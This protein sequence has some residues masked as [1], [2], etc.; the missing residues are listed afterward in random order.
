MMQLICGSGVCCAY[1]PSGL[2]VTSLG[3]VVAAASRHFL[4]AAT[5]ITSF[6]SS[7]ACTAAYNPPF[8]ASLL[9]LHRSGR[10]I[11]RNQNDQYITLTPVK[12][13]LL[14]IL[15]NAPK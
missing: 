14:C 6:P 10:S 15:R 13:S 9:H 1:K 11:S 7:M 8:F 3:I 5:V 4:P 2:S 12:K